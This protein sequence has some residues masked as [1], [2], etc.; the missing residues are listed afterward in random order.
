MPAP[1]SNLPGR[2]WPGRPP[3]LFGLAPNGVCRA[4]R[5]TTASGGLLH[6]RFTLTRPKPGGLLSVAL[7][8]GCPSWMLSSVLPCGARTFLP[9]VA[10]AA[11]IRPTPAIWRRMGDKK[12]HTRP[13]RML[14]NAVRPFFMRRNLLIRQRL[15]LGRALGRFSNCEMFAPENEALAVG[16]AQYLLPA[17]QF[18]ERLRRN[19][20]VAA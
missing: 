11:T 8:E 3:S 15:R 13:G 19:G 1:S 2:L 9:G 16:A 4:C 20:N 12:R 14:L 17:L 18:D 6:H 5:V 10:P 7:S